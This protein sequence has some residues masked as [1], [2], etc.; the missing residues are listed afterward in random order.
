MDEIK[1]LADRITSLIPDYNGDYFLFS[2]RGYE[3]YTISEK[4]FFKISQLDLD[5]SVA[6]IDA[7][8]AEIFSSP[9][10][11]LHFIRVF[12]SVWRG[13][14]REWIKKY[15][16]YSL[17]HLIT[18]QNNVSCN[19]EIM[20]IKEKLL[21]N[22]Q[23]N[24]L[25][26]TGEGSV[27]I[28]GI[29]QI[30]RRFSELKAASLLVDKLEE[31]SILLLDGTL[32]ARSEEEQRLL[33]ELYGKALKR[34]VIIGALAKTT[35]LFTKK[36]NS[37][38]ALL[39]TIGP[40]NPWYYFPVVEINNDAHKARVFFVKLHEKSDYVFRFESFN[41]NRFNA[42]EFF[43]FLSFLSRDVSF[44][45]Y[46]YGLVDADRFARISNE[47]S[48]LLKVKFVARAGKNFEKL[49]K[50]ANAINAHDVLNGMYF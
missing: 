20:P 7:G 25:E 34:N 18:E 47:E 46:P 30:V 22:L 21:E 29:G 49:K 1:G 45:G 28:S 24:K 26:K 27:R 38:A 12:C 4:N 37:A 48:E 8:N 10:F 40:K 33:D 2:S 39:N 36:G 9:N 41:E 17:A 19:V 44:L 16:M 15:E 14:K 11:S 50:Y 3:P 32:Q 5:K 31:N 42:N 6:F 13:K 35:N 23:F 43:G